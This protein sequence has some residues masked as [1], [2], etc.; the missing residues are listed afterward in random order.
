MIKIFIIF[1]FILSVDN[2]KNVFYG[3]MTF[4][5]IVLVKRR[6]RRRKT[7]TR[8]RTRRRARRRRTR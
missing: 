6:R 2:V 3:T 8:R 1:F 4:G 7:R 5:T